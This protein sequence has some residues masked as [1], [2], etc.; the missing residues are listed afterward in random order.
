M[1]LL[2]IYPILI[3]FAIAATIQGVIKVRSSGTSEAAA[4]PREKAWK[5]FRLAFWMFLSL[6]VLI[7]F[8]AGGFFGSLW[9]AAAVLLIG[10]F[11]YVITKNAKYVLLGAF[12][13]FPTLAKGVLIA[14]FLFPGQIPMDKAYPTYLSLKPFL[15]VLGL[16][17]GYMLV[18]R[19]RQRRAMPR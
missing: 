7:E 6:Y 13:A 18:R 3:V 16:L 12:G 17:C 11:A 19:E 15:F 1:D 14:M 5:N 9:E 8:W 4:D 2:L 10:L